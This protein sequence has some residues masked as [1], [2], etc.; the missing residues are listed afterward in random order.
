M[1]N[2]WPRTG[3]NQVPQWLGLSNPAC[4]FLAQ[5][6]MQIT[7]QSMTKQLHDSPSV[8]WYCGLPSCGRELGN[9]TLRFC[10]AIHLTLLTSSHSFTCSPVRFSSQSF[11]LLE[12]A[13]LVFWCLAQFSVTP[14]GLLSRFSDPCFCLLLLCLEGALG[15]SGAWETCCAIWVLRTL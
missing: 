3:I 8:L 1:G 7:K 9:T 14:C 6:G 2:S 5:L 15:I 13:S 10:S 12:K 4:W 11:A